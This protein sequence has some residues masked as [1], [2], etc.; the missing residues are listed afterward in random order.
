MAGVTAVA[1]IER[2]ADISRDLFTRYWRD[3][4]GVMAA[5]IPG[6]ESYVQHHVTRIGG[7][8]NGPDFEGIAVVR[9]ASEADRAGLGNSAISAEIVRDEPNVFSRAL[10]YNLSGEETLRFNEG[11]AARRDDTGFRLFADAGAS[12]EWAQACSDRGIEVHLHDV[13]GADPSLWNGIEGDAASWQAVAQ[14]WPDGHDLPTCNSEVRVYRTDERYVMVDRGRPTPIGL[15]GADAV[16]TIREI[17]ADNQLDS[18]VEKLIY[19][20]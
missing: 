10:L 8:D 20:L 3:V 4:H 18:T 7:P 9:F 1:L 12:R 13:R 6:F 11:A 17:G 19:G 16:R 15:R 2:R 14:F 5:R